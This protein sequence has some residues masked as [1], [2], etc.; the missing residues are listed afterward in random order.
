MEYLGKPNVRI[1]SFP[2]YYDVLAKMSLKKVHKS[3]FLIFQ[4]RKKY[5]RPKTKP[6]EFEIPLT[7]NLVPGRHP[8]SLACTYTDN[9]HDVRHT[10]HWDHNHF[11]RTCHKLKKLFSKKLLKGGT[12]WDI[13]RLMIK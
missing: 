4:V 7:D 3:L 10:W 6:R 11:L 9:L 5:E 13:G 1:Y 2:L 8:Y 12:T